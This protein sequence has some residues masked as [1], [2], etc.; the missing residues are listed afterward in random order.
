M[1][2]SL[3]PAAAALAGALHD[4]ERSLAASRALWDDRARHIFDHRHGDPIIADGKRVLMALQELAVEL[5]T[6]M[7]TLDTQ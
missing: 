5:K 1:S 3:E 2:P 4:L 6:A 7:R